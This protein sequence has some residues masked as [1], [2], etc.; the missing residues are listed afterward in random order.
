MRKIFLAESKSKK[1]FAIGSWFI[2]LCEHTKG[3]HVFIYWPRKNG[4][5]ISYQATG[6]GVNFCGALVLKEEHEIV[7]R[8]ELDIE[9]QK[10][11]DLLTWAIDNCGKN[12]SRMHLVGLGLMRLASLFKLKIKNYFADGDYSQVCVEAAIRC[13]TAA[14]I[15]TDLDPEEAGLK[16]IENWILAN[17]KPAL[18]GL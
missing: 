9:D 2:R 13:L 18:G 11:E 1:K 15:K 5:L 7:D 4:Q 8:L 14:G 16:E 3:S 6:H 12:Y 10:Y 17:K